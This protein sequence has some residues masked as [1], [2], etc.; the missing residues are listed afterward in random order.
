MLGF[1]LKRLGAGVV[2]VWV[3]AT[4]TFFLTN[5]TGS[6]PARRI[7]GAQADAA[8][9]LAKRQELGLDRPVLERYWDWLTSAV[10]GDLGVSWFTN[11]PVGG[12]VADALPISL[13]LVIAAIVL[14]AL[15]SVVI[16]VLAAVRG[17][18]VDSAL[19]GASILAFAVPNFLVGL[20]LA[21]VFAVQL[22]LFPAIGYTPFAQDPGLWAASITL[23]AVALAIGATATVATQTRGSMIDVLGQDYVRT[24][25]SRGLPTRSI[26]LKHALRNAAPASLTV[27][28]LQFI[29]LISGA[30]VIEKVFGLNGIGERATS[31]ASQGDVPV[32]LGVVV[33]TV[34]LVVVVN[35]L[36]DLA[37]G[38]L[39]PKVRTA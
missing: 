11:Q 20:L 16:G 6:D 26:L 4:A 3:T 13:S 8:T 28:S 12:T 31:A 5:A 9:V 22:G 38:W 33:L 35:L 14:T 23:P 32:V 39:N 29:A 17:G 34:V 37:L 18:W 1:L 25:R 30:V 15:V 7:V 2:L 10:H 24:L 21:L 27:L 19:Q 36:A